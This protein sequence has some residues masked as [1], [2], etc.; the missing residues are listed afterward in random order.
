MEQ[1]IYLKQPIIPVGGSGEAAPSSRSSTQSGVSFQQV[2][3][4]EIAGVKFSQH[5]QQRLK[6]RNIQMSAQEIQKINGGLEK[7]S[8]K[9]AKESLMVMGDLA[10]IVNVPNKTVITVMDGQSI[11]EN[12]FTNIDSAI[13]L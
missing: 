5:A 10:M 7:V 8:R 1:K 3:Q 11:K 4:Q 6:L 13:I 9:G 2:L 12:V